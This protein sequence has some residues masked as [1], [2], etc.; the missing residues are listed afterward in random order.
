MPSKRT[1]RLNKLKYS[2]EFRARPQSTPIEPPY[3]K[4][5]TELR[6]RLAVQQLEDNLAAFTRVHAASLHWTDPAKRQAAPDKQETPSRDGLKV[7]TDHETCKGSPGGCST[8][9]A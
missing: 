8:E 6:H 7:S 4:G 2:T 1:K 9:C 5:L 3:Q